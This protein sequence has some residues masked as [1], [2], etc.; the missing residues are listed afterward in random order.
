MTDALATPQSPIETSAE[1]P[2]PPED[3]LLKLG[4]FARM[5][6]RWPFNKDYE[7]CRDEGSAILLWMEKQ[8][9]DNYHR[10]SFDVLFGEGGELQQSP[11]KE[12]Q[13]MKGLWDLVEKSAEDFARLSGQMIAAY[14][15]GSPEPVSAES[16]QIV[17]EAPYDFIKNRYG[18]AAFAVV[19]G[20]TRKTQNKINTT[21][22]PL[23]TAPVSRPPLSERIEEYAKKNQSLEAYLSDDVSRRKDLYSCFKKFVT[24][25]RLW[26]E[27]LIENATSSHDVKDA[28]G[29]VSSV[30]I[31]VVRFPLD[32]QTRRTLVIQ[33]RYLRVIDII[34]QII[35]ILQTLHHQMPE[36]SRMRREEQIP[37][38]YHPIAVLSYYLRHVLPYVIEEDNCSLNDIIEDIIAFVLHDVAEDTCQKVKEAIKKVMA[39]D[40][41][42]SAIN[43]DEIIKSAFGRTREEIV[44]RMLK[45]VQPEMT[46]NMEIVLEAL[47]N[48]VLLSAEDYIR[49]ASSGVLPKEYIAECY[50]AETDR[51]YEKGGE[52]QIHGNGSRGVIQN[53]GTDEVAFTLDI[54]IDGL[55]ASVNQS[56][57]ARKHTFVKEFPGVDDH[58][59][60][61]HILR[62]EAFTNKRALRARIQKVKMFDRSHN[63][64][65]E[66]SFVL[67]DSTDSSYKST[68]KKVQGSRKKLR[69]AVSILLAYNIRDQDNSKYSL[70]LVIPVNIANTLQTY[71]RFAREC[72]QL[73]EEKDKQYIE[74]LKEFAALFPIRDLPQHYR[75]VVCDFNEARA[76]LTNTPQKILGDVSL[77]ASVIS[78]V[79]TEPVE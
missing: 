67:P 65:T 53:P 11:E 41:V 4:Y 2:K 18:Q 14:E 54:D 43:K 35:P 38:I 8:Q 58:K 69:A 6:E 36:G 3:A 27:M 29:K 15:Q 51:A 34:H 70:D 32:P 73:T 17:A 56:K 64:V 46:K 52:V 24:V 78:G 63:N 62:A 49:L 50:K 55:L 60:A 22:T 16:K 74:K 33:N 25:L 10:Y 31:K 79:S 66:G 45:L 28:E 47:S 21:Q 59:M 75:E 9:L 48:R 57:R 42:D 19:E 77:A 61:L 72:P 30:P 20:A 44:E 71:N 5:V 37:F 26:H 13:Y 1:R 12:K 76:R 40:H 68:L 39:H 7:N 23:P